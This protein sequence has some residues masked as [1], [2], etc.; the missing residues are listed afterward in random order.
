MISLSARTRQGTAVGWGWVGE[1]RPAILLPYHPA[2]Y[3]LSFKC[4]RHPRPTYHTATVWSTPQTDKID[5]SLSS[6]GQVA[7]GGV[8]VRVW[9]NGGN[10]PGWGGVE[11]GGVR[12][13][14]NGGNGPGWGGVKGGGVRV[15]VNGGNGPGWGGV[16]GGGVRV[17]VNGGK[18]VGQRPG[19]GWGKGVGQRW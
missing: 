2:V 10:G 9:V 19:V 18:G 1:N 6:R 16:K 8:G 3:P 11:G 4:N 14:V 15:W 17:W 13:W 12:V 5:P 7:P